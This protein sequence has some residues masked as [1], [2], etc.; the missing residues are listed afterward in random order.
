MSVSVIWTAT[1]ANT[2]TVLVDGC[3]T[4]LSGEW[5]NCEDNAEST[6]QECCED[7]FRGS[8]Y[9][10]LEDISVTVTA[11]ASIA[12]PYEVLLRRIVKATVIKM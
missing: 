4:I 6:V 5:A 10:D 12:G 7:Y 3:E 1:E 11:P 2:E 8:E 9:E